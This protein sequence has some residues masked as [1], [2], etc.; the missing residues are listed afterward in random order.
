MASH[1]I[2]AEI[3]AKLDQTSLRSAVDQISSSLQRAGASVNISVNAN[4]SQLKSLEDAANSATRSVTGLR[5]GLAE[6]GNQA[7]FANQRLLVLANTTGQ[8]PAV[9]TAAAA[10]SRASAAGVVSSAAAT[11]AAA[12]TSA[13]SMATM[14]VS[15]NAASVSLRGLG[16]QAGLSARRML[17]FAIGGGAILALAGAIRKTIG[18]AID[19]ERQLAK[20]AAVSGAT[21]SELASLKKTITDVATEYGASSSELLQSSVRLKQLGLNAADTATALEALAKAS[22][23]PS[24]GSMNDNISAV[25]ATIRQFNVGA[26]EFENILGSMNA[27]SAKFAVNAGDFGEAIKAS[28]SA[29]KSAGGD[30]RELLALFTTVKDTTQESSHGIA[31]GLRTIFTRLERG[32]TL[33]ALKNLGIELRRTKEEAEAAGDLGLKG[34]FVGAFEALQRLSDGLAKLPTN[35]SQYASVVEQVGGYREINKLLPLLQNMGE[36]Q[37]ALN[38]AQVGGAS[39]DAAAS[40]AKETLAVR[41]HQVREEF[42]A[43]GRAVVED[44]GFQSVARDALLV[45]SAFI[46]MLDALRPLIPL[47]AVL[48]AIKLAQNVGGLVSGFASRFTSA[49]RGSLTPPGRPLGFS[50]GGHVGGSGSGDTVPA[51]LE[52]HEFVINRRSASIIGRAKLERLNQTGS[53]GAAAGTQYFSRGGAVGYA[54]GGDVDA[55]TGAVGDLGRAAKEAAESLRRVAALVSQVETPNKKGLSFSERIASK[56]QDDPAAQAAAQDSLFTSAKRF[57]GRPEIQPGGEF[58]TKEGE[59]LRP[60]TDAYKAKFLSSTSAVSAAS[61]AARYAVY[62]NVK[63]P[64]VI[65]PA[66]SDEAR[67]AHRKAVEAYN[68]KRR[69]KRAASTSTFEGDEIDVA[70]PEASAP[71]S[72]AHA[73]ALQRLHGLQTGGKD[74]LKKYLRENKVKVDLRKG[75]DTLRQAATSH[76]TGSLAVEDNNYLSDAERQKLIVQAN[77]EQVQRSIVKPAVGADEVNSTKNRLRERLLAKRGNAGG[78]PAAPAGTDL[79]SLRQPVAS[80][81]VQDDTIDA[82]YV[83]GARNRGLLLPPANLPAQPPNQPPRPPV[84]AAAPG[85]D[86]DARRERARIRYEAAKRGS[87]GSS[88]GNQRFDTGH[89]PITILG[90]D[91]NPIDLSR[92]AR[93]EAAQ[94]HR[95]AE[96]GARF[97]RNGG[98]DIPD[99]PFPTGSVVARHTSPEDASYQA[100]Q[101]RGDRRAA[102][103]AAA[104]ARDAILSNATSFGGTGSFLKGPAAVVAGVQS[105]EPRRELL[106]DLIGQGAVARTRAEIARRGGPDLLSE[107]TQSDI[108]GKEL[109]RETERVRRDLLK[110][111]E[112]LL[113][114]THDELLSTEARQKASERVQAALEGRARVLVDGTGKILGTDVSGAEALNKGVGLVKRPATTTGGIAR[115]AISDTVGGIRDRLARLRESAGDV[116][117]DPSKSRV[118]RF[119]SRVDSFAQGKLGTGAAIAGAVLLPVATN[120]LNKYAGTADLAVTA[121]REGRFSGFSA[122]GSAL[123]GAAVGG[124]IGGTLGSIVPV[125]GTVVGATLGAAAGGIA[126]FVT[127]LQDAEKE[128]RQVKIGNAISTFA[129]RLSDI[130][131][132][133]PA[134]GAGYEAAKSI[135]EARAGLNQHNAD[136]AT[137]FFGGFDL[138]E[139]KA[140]QDKSLKTDFGTHLPQIQAAIGSQA[141]QIGRANAGSADYNSL[142]KQLKDGGDGFGRELLRLSAELRKISPQKSDKEA[143]DAIARGQR[144]A[145]GLRSAGDVDRAA[146]AFSRLLR[147]VEAAQ[148]SLTELHQRADA[149]GTAFEGGL[150]PGKVTANVRNLAG[151]GRND[152]GV[153]APLGVVRATG[154]AQGESLFQTGR[155]VNDVQNLLPSV[156]ATVRSQSPLNGAGFAEQVEAGLTRQLG[157]RAKDPEVAKVLREVVAN[158]HRDT[159]GQGGVAAEKFNEQLR[160]D[161]SKYAEHLT[162]KSA[163]AVKEFGGK[164][165]KDLEDEANQFIDAM[166]RSR[167]RLA[168]VGEAQ[169]RVAAVRLSSQRT[170]TEQ[171]AEA[172]FQRHGATDLLPLSALQAPFAARQERLTGEAGDAANDPALIGR[173][174]AKA[175]QEILKG[176]ESQQALFQKTGGQGGAF[177][178]AAKRLAELKGNAANLQ[179]AL[180]HLADASERNAAVQEKLSSIT[181]DRDSRVSFGERYLTADAGERAEI[182]RSLV[183]ANAA[184]N[185]GNL[186]RFSDEEIKS[187]IGV[188]RSL[189]SAK[190]TGFQGQPVAADLL[191]KLV[192]KSGG[193][194]FD[195]SGDRKTEEDALRKQLVE[196]A[197]KSEEAAK[198]LFENQKGLQESFFQTLEQTHAQFFATLNAN[199]ARDKISGAVGRLGEASVGLGGQRDLQGKAAD[200]KDLLGVGSDKELR[201]ALARVADIRNIQ[202][203][204]TEVANL[205]EGSRGAAVRA[206]DTIENTQNKLSGLTGLAAG[207]AGRSSLLAA[208]AFSNYVGGPK[209]GG[210]PPGKF[211]AGLS[212]AGV[213]GDPQKIYDRYRELAKE[214]LAAAGLKTEDGTF[215]SPVTRVNRLRSYDSAEGRKALREALSQSI[216]ENTDLSFKDQEKSIAASRDRLRRVGVKADNIGVSPDQD[217][218]INEALKPFADQGKKL[219]GLSASVDEAKKKFDDLTV[220]I[221]RLKR[222]AAG[223]APQLP[224]IG[225]PGGLLPT[226]FAGGGKARG[227]DTVPAMLTPGEFVVSRD[228]AQANIGLLRKI[229]G[230]RG[231]RFMADGGDPGVGPKPGETADQYNKRA[232]A[233]S[234]RKERVTTRPPAYVPA[235]PYTP[236][237]VP[238]DTTP[239]KPEDIAAPA[240]VGPEAIAAPQSVD[241]RIADLKEKIRRERLAHD[242]AAVQADATPPAELIA[243]PTPAATA[244]ARRGRRPRR[245]AIDGRDLTVGIAGFGGSTGVGS[246]SNASAPI[247]GPDLGN[248]SVGLPIS[249]SSRGIGENPNGLK[250]VYAAPIG[251][252]AARNGFDRIKYDYLS[253]KREAARQVAAAGTDDP[254]LRFLAASNP[255]GP[256]AQLLARRAGATAAQV[257]AV[258]Y[259]G[260][261]RNLQARQRLANQ[262]SPLPGSDA[263]RGIAVG[264][265]AKK[266][267][268]ENVITQRDYDLARLRK[269]SQDRAGRTQVVRGFAAGGAVDARDTI[270]AMLADGEYVLNSRATSAIGRGNLDRVNHFAGGGPVGAVSGESGSGLSPEVQQALARFGDSASALG[271]GLKGF[272]SSVQSFARAGTILGEGA[273]KL[274]EA[275]GKIPSSITVTGSQ[276]V[277]VV[278][279]G[280][281]A[282]AAASPAIQ[283]LVDEAVRKQIGKAFKENL[284]DAGVGQF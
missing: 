41:A 195:V 116:L 179:A 86:D 61:S 57:L 261:V 262:T 105:A 76:L 188:L 275:V 194:V 1:N 180:R 259:A 233:E 244:Q 183:L 129:D 184:N 125:V 159:E 20:V 228:A 219:D 236:P 282:L 220:E 15:A 92:I 240:A 50:G 18:E 270:P 225:L 3:T 246:S 67:E 269:Q 75:E 175:N 126:G 137:H 239:R 12:R 11:A 85:G 69:V 16:D 209:T 82:D 42:L 230:G 147:S 252:A 260:Q 150:S 89:D 91:G 122:A 79:L 154:G 96:A 87:G 245:P 101:A 60:G 157:G 4:Q 152:P 226:G 104:N 78:G 22:L 80:R 231:T 13:A 193:G 145:A 283:K 65:D 107:K 149:L 8:L 144:Q 267:D 171:F 56:Y 211:A 97:R 206:V 273:S 165:A 40:K 197:K 74:D 26:G 43:L 217:A 37:R 161:V 169:D 242:A 196:N 213:Q 63:D 207:D 77:A 33:D 172:S 14:A 214:K 72:D 7:S 205:K 143:V 28:G 173:K 271:A 177:D 113:R 272:D 133:N 153:L 52:P 106:N 84:D 232:L 25:A 93:E 178:E 39:V 32:S 166:S 47:L 141:E 248:G 35:S 53:L 110:T 222:A 73:E 112:Q 66:A 151:L 167:Q 127:G 204:S 123:Q 94:R 162:E 29:F 38:I 186:D 203:K 281:E 251:V 45:A 59:L 9:M 102:Q 23:A 30:V 189:G 263:Q 198:E 238:G 5:Q 237:V 276:R 108:G 257:G 163:G 120:Q 256:A 62:G 243:A 64:G 131:S 117:T 258:A 146:T 201:A 202:E 176:T 223:P 58:L 55:N 216:T 190:L 54:G 247:P 250:G 138:K 134:A 24:F 274:A 139:Y 254:D 227:T 255:Y 135:R 68:D 181:R 119:T 218:R 191:E 51:M 128:I 253:K 212:D 279:L 88:A 100:Q 235:V 44:K 182:N 249:E 140:L 142:L 114:R 121:G 156:L 36:A 130:A 70:A 229:N 71:I 10:A 136:E 31:T 148:D 284:P 168:A 224:N 34:Q 160:S 241:E 99:G 158:I 155:A 115:E 118:G 19:F 132:G 164:Y 210:G 95:D 208:V 221:E 27:L 111:E 48:G 103:T 21:Q 187:I 17:G 277:E 170:Q 174:L 83:I 266:A 200:L 49:P 2:V 124:A 98:I 46:K 6:L 280:A 81:P 264:N 265:L 268:L 109:S 215:D 278:I 192:R 90:D 185:R 199:L 234:I